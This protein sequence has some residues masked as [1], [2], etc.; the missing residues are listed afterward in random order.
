MPL[1]LELIQLSLTLMAV[2]GIMGA[3]IAPPL[4]VDAAR[5]SAGV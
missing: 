4:M 2:A 1:F 3:L 5:K